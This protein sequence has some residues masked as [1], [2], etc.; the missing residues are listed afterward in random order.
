MMWTILLVGI[1]PNDLFVWWAWSTA[2]Y[3]A[4]VMLNDANNASSA[5]NGY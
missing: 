2:V 3:C 4:G 1:I 5:N